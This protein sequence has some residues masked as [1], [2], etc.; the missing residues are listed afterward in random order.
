[1]ALTGAGAAYVALVEDNAP[2]ELRPLVAAAERPAEEAEGADDE[3]EDAPAED[4]EP[5]PDQAGVTQP[6]AR[7]LQ[8]QGPVNPLFK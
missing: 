8:V 6:P 5:G 1:M 4:V 3:P 7:M 2:P